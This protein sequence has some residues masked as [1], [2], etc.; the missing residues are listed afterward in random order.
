MGSKEVD[1]DTL[2]MNRRDLLRASAVGAGAALA[3]GGRRSARAAQE[4]GTLRVYWNPGHQYAAYQQV[5]DRFEQDHP[6]WTV[7]WEFYQWPDMRTKLLADFAANNPPDLSAEPG[8]W[9]QEFALA[10]YLRS[11]QPHVDADGEAMGFPADWQ[12]YTVDRNSLDGQVYG[13]QLHLTCMLLFYNRRMLAEAGIAQPPTDWDGFL[14]AAQAMTDGPVFGTAPN[15]DEGYAWPWLLQNGVRY[16]DPERNVVPMDTPEA[17]EA[18]QYVADLIHEHKVAPLPPTTG[19]YAGPQKLFSAERAAMIITGPWDIKPI[20]EGSPGLDWGIAQA[21][22]RRTQS[23]VAAGVSVMIPQQAK[24]PDLAWDLVKRFTA[25]E[26]EVAATQE[27]GMTMPRLSWGQQPEVQGLERIAPFAQGLGYAQDY[28]AELRLTGQSGPIGEL[29]RKAYQDI[30]YR[31]VPAA[32]AL[33]EFTA[34]ANA[35][36][37]G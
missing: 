17:A 24:N 10:G 20:L 11:L 19:D 4:G 14:A 36:L 13:V 16:Y 2:R 37:A 30:I 1:V 25:L 15:Q 18:L 29:Y 34:A 35:L 31:R 12:P 22:T 7:N 5:I 33:A 6:G 9:V 8:G 27:A 21:L 32:D 26:T 3:A 23:T 28:T